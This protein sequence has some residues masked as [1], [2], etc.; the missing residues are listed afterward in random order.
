MVSWIGGGLGVSE[1]VDVVGRMVSIRDV[2]DEEEV[3]VIRGVLN[4]G[5]EVVVSLVEQEEEG[6]IPEYLLMKLNTVRCHTKLF[7]CFKTQ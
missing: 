3:V 6:V 4:G 1:R 5:I 2:E 7:S